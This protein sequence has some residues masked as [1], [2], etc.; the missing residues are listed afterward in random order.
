[1]G[2]QGAGDLPSSGAVTAYQESDVL[3]Q[4]P[5]G[6]QGADGLPHS[7]GVGAHHVPDVL[8]QG[9]DDLLQVGDVSG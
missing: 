3:Q 9:A 5:V 8:Q 2:A 1:M 4:A 6:V 7:G